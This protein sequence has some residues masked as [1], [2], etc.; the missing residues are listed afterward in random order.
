MKDIRTK[1]LAKTL[2]NYSLELKKG[3]KLLV[4]NWGLNTELIKEIIKE[5]HEVGALPHVSIKDKSVFRNLLM[6]TSVEHIES[7]TK[8]DL[9]RMKDMDAYISIKAYDNYNEWVDLPSEKLQLYMKHYYKKVHMEESVNK[10][11]WCTL[12]Y[13]TAAMAQ[14]ANMSIEGLEDWYYKVCN[15]DYA[16]MIEASK[17]LVDLMEKTD[18]VRIVSKDTDLKFSIKNMPI[19]VLAGKHN[20]PDCEVMTVP[21]KDS[22]EGYIKY[23]IPSTYQSVRYHNV[24]LEF[25]KG[26]IINA[27]ADEQDKIDKVL[28][29][30]EGARY[31]GEFAIG[32]N[33]YILHPID[34]ILFDE[35]ITGSIHFTPGNSYDDASNGN[36]SSI[37]WDLVLILREDY[38]GGE[39]YFDDHLIYKDGLFILEEL[40]ALNPKNLI[41]AGYNA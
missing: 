30:D 8:Y 7:I 34:D 35:K 39:I 11:K 24:R 14:A 2:I 9:N 17:G 37:H 29:I 15:L 13:P 6:N 10:K 36:K 32:F 4:D 40:E 27:F 22:V 38:G 26:K 20:I 41:A 5:A 1:K 25:N 12:L 33:P 21:V 3:E 28:D 16:K 19:K 23:N 31:I 18:N